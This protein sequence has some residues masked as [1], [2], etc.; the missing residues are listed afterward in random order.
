[1]TASPASGAFGQIE[2]D[3][4]RLICQAA[5]ADDGRPVLIEAFEGRHLPADGRDF[6]PVSFAEALQLTGLPAADPWETV[7]RRNAVARAMLELVA[8]L[9][10]PCEA[11][12]TYRVYGL[13]VPD[14]LRGLSIRDRFC[15]RVAQLVDLDGH[16]PVDAAALQF[17]TWARHAFEPTEP[18]PGPEGDRHRAACLARLDA[19]R[20]MALTGYDR[21]LRALEDRVAQVQ[22]TVAAELARALWA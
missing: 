12:I 9:D 3:G 2:C 15:L 22:D 18:R 20:L 11:Q 16:G 6:A 5:R 7:R 10:V 4:T 14:A 1:M 17:L 13:P 19:R 21:L 8:E